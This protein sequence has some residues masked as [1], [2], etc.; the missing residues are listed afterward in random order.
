MVLR[1]RVGFRREGVPLIV[2]IVSAEE[3]PLLSDSD[4]VAAA[5]DLLASAASDPDGALLVG[6]VAPA[7][8]HGLVALAKTFGDNGAFSAVTDAAWTSLPFTTE[9]HLAVDGW[10][11]YRDCLDWPVVDTQPGVEGIQPDCVA[12]EIHLSSTERTEEILPSC[13]DNA[14]V[15]GR[16]W[17]TERNPNPCPAGEFEFLVEP[18]VL[19]CLPNYSIRFSLTCAVRYD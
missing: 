16:C 17:R 5:H 11:G 10:P 8:A 18:R 9:L 7:S 2:A 13:S 19:A 12:T 15:P 14:S 3:D 1:S 6:V 4:A